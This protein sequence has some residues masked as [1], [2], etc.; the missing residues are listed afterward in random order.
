MS[1]T[2]STETFV[3]ANVRSLRLE[4][5][6]SNEELATGAG[7]SSTKVME[8][9]GS[10]S[11]ES[12]DAVARVLSKKLGRVITAA[13]LLKRPG[14]QVLAGWRQWRADCAAAKKSRRRKAG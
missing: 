9:T 13:D 12:L 5:K 7:L 10:A 3:G 1:S 14:D 11:I 8:A 2:Q 4:A 6:L